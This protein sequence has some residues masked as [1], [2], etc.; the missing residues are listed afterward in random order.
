MI[1]RNINNL[2]NKINGI[3]FHFINNFKFKTIPIIISKYAK[4]LKC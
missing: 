1:P 2:D 4:T 3:F